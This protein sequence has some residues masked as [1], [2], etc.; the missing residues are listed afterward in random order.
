MTATDGG[1]VGRFF[2]KV[3]CCSF[4]GAEAYPECLR[5]DGEEA[6]LLYAQGSALSGVRYGCRNRCS[7]NKKLLII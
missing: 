4:A 5:R 1:V 7:V 2:G 6:M 3:E